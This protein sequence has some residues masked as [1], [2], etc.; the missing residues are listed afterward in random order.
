VPPTDLIRPCFRELFDEG[1]RRIPASLTP[2]ARVLDA[3]VRW[4]LLPRLGYRD[5]YT[6]MGSPSPYLS[7]TV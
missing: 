3:I 4:T 7:D 5:M 2:L 6:A 1:S